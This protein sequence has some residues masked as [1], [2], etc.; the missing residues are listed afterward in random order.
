ERRLEAKPYYTLL[1]RLASMRGLIQADQG[2]FDGATHQYE[3][4]AT[5]FERTNDVENQA[6]T[7]NLLADTQRVLG[8]FSEAWRVRLGALSRLDRLR[9]QRQEGLLLATARLAE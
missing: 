5:Y 6:S 8:D 2:A 9:T 3:R 7:A 1:G 4:A